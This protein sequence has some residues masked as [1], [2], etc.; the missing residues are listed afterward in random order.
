MP[1]CKKILFLLISLP[2]W[3]IWKE[4]RTMVHYLIIHKYIYMYI[5]IYIIYI[6]VYIKCFVYYILYIYY[7]HM[8]RNKNH[9]ALSDYTSIHYL[10]IYTYIYYIYTSA[11]QMLSILYTI[12]ILHT[13]YILYNTY[14]YNSHQQL[15][16]A[17]DVILTYNKYSCSGPLAFKSGSCRLRFS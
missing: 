7:I 3:S 5:H 2:W 11:Y 16:D 1:R 10:Y 15:Q 12:Y 8:K 17:L 4:T 13:L 14:L 6:Q 9:G